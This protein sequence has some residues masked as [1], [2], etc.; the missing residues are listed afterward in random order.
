M[1]SLAGLDAAVADAPGALTGLA[2]PTGA[3]PVAR[4]VQRTLTD[5]YLGALV[6]Q[7]QTMHARMTIQQQEKSKRLSGE[8]VACVRQTLIGFLPRIGEGSRL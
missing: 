2:G 1:T 5:T 8:L 6:T 7:L 4:N 3:A